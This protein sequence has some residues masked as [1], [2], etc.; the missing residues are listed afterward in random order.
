MCD[1]EPLKARIEDLR[2]QL[3]AEEDINACLELQKRIS[4][5]RYKLQAHKD[6]ERHHSVQ[7]PEYSFPNSSRY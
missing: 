4:I 5:L 2:K 1:I 7:M 3:E 6:R